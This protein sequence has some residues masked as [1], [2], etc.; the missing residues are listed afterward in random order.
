MNKK[1]KKEKSSTV[2]DLTSRKNIRII[3]AEPT[4]ISDD[5]IMELEK[6]LA[7]R[8][9]EM[10]EFYN[11]ILEQSKKEKSKITDDEFNSIMKELIKRHKVLKCLINK[12]T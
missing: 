5:E 4:H 9:K 7:V 8:S 3:Q 2:I 11:Y 6:R 10:D 1:K 12:D